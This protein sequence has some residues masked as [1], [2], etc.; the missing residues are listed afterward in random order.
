MVFSL[1]RMNPIVK[2]DLTL[3]SLIVYTLTFRV[4]R[5][6]VHRQFVYEFKTQRNQEMEKQSGTELIQCQ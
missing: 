4:P 6:S 2:C 5:Q 3:G 1:G